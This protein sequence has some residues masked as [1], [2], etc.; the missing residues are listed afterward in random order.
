MRK[1]DAR[2]LTPYLTVG[3]ETLYI[4][5][6]YIVFPSLGKITEFAFFSLIYRERKITEFFPIFP[7]EN[8]VIYVFFPLRENN[9]FYVFFLVTTLSFISNPPCSFN[10][11]RTVFSLTPMNS[12]RS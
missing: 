2:L 8:N 6:V 12:D 7:R 4:Y 1:L 10:R 5:V 9:V 11:F 3:K